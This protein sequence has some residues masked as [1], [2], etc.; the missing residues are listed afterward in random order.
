[1][2]TPRIS[3]TAQPTVDAERYLLPFELACSSNT[4]SPK[5]VVTA[6]DCIQK[7]IAYGHLSGNSPDPMN[8]RRRVIDRLVDTICQ[9]FQGPLTDE[10]VQLQIIKALLTIVTSHQCQIHERTLLEAVRTCYN[11]YMASRSLVNQKTA[12]ATLTQMLNVIFKR[13]EDF[14]PSDIGDRSASGTSLASTPLPQ[15]QSEVSINFHPSICS[16][17]YNVKPNIIINQPTNDKCFRSS[18]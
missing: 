1:M 7:L 12:R 11:I 18:L 14:V 4:K 9:C 5:V 6:L 8:T 16:I 13:M 17:T 2:P 15:S 10:D 3:G